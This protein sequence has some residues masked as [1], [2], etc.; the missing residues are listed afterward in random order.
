[1]TAAPTSSSS[2]VVMP[3]RTARFMASSMR[4]TMA[5]AAR[6]P[7]RSSGP[8]M[9]MLLAYRIGRT[10]RGEIEQE[11]ETRH[12][13][14]S[15]LHE[16]KPQKPQN[17]AIERYG[18]TGHEDQEVGR[19]PGIEGSSV[20]L[21]G[22]QNF[23][24]LRQPAAPYCKHGCDQTDRNSRDGVKNEGG[25]C[26]RSRSEALSNRRIEHDGQEQEQ[27]NGPDELER[28]VHNSDSAPERS[29]AEEEITFDVPGSAMGEQKHC[30]ALLGLDGSETRPHTLWAFDQDPV[31]F[32]RS[33]SGRRSRISAGRRSCT[34]RAPSLA[35]STTAMGAGVATATPSQIKAERANPTS[36][37]SSSQK[38]CRGLRWRIT[39]KAMRKTA[40]ESDARPIRAR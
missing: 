37:A 32:R 1:M 22:G 36:A 16:R 11:R 10:A 8:V 19:S 7:A 30:R 26:F 20:F 39:P 31:I 2:A 38:A 27:T 4:R 24:Q 3:G 6:M 21:M 33:S 5:P 15:H 14:R 23:L 35:A 9:D 40:A 25:L 34:R 12:I 18:F 13:K 29:L 28:T 17:Q